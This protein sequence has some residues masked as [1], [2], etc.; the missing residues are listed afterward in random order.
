MIQPHLR[1]HRLETG[2]LLRSK[3]KLW[4]EAFR[5][6]QRDDGGR[7]SWGDENIKV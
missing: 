4:L 6:E 2:K 1:P 7:M 3:N 5:G